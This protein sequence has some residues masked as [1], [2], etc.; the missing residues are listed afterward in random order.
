MWHTLSEAAGGLESE[1]PTAE[2]AVQDLGTDHVAHA[3]VV[4]AEQRGRQQVQLHPALAVPRHRAFIPA[5][6]GWPVQ[7][8]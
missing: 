4:S 7:V 8:C 2:G 3:R 5:E 1:R 6:L